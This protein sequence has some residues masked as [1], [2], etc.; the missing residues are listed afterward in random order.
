MIPR[1]YK[2]GEWKSAES[3][4]VFEKTFVGMLHEAISCK[5]TKALDSEYTYTLEMLYPISGEFYPEIV[6]RTL[7]YAKPDTEHSAQLFEVYRITTPIE[8]AIKV[9]ANHISYMLASIPTPPFLVPKGVAASLLTLQ[10]SSKNL[11]LHG[12]QLAVDPDSNIASSAVQMEMELPRS[13]RS[14]LVGSEGSYIDTFGG[15]LEFDGFNVT[16]KDRLGRDTLTKIRYGLNM[17]AFE[18]DE[19]LTTVYTGIYPYAINTITDTETGETLSSVVTIPDKILY[20][21]DDPPC[22]RV[23]VIDLTSKFTENGIT[24]DI[25]PANLLEAAQEYISENQ[26]GVPSVN[27][28][29]SFV[30]LSQTEEYRDTVGIEEVS[31]GDTVTVDYPAVGITATARCVKT[32]YDSV[33]ERYDSIEIGKV[34]RTIVDTIAQMRRD[35]KKLR[36]G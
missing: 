35:I 22:K 13:L 27:I 33:A 10:N 14:A 5:V 9:Y 25:T 8:G 7:I 1:L 2:N 34:K 3:G 30:S 4:A 19:N 17:T 32:V 23:K 29:V 21:S 15:E 12:F 6:C 31:L 26:W 18:H 28:K 36:R 24:A 20:A 11:V 16:V